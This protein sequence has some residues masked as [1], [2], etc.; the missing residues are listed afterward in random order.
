ML[1]QDCLTRKL[2]FKVGVDGSRS[3]SRFG[4]SGSHHDH[5]ELSSAR[6]LD[7]V[8]IAIAVTGVK[9][10]YWRRDQKIAP[11]GIACAFPFAAL[12]TPST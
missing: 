8:K 1:V 9:R 7:H 11:A 4:Q 12:L 5:G 3:W 6:D 2:H 10:I